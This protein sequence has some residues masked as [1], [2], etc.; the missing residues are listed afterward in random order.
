M[1]Q[2]IHTGTHVP[3]HVVP[4]VQGSARASQWNRSQWTHVALHVEQHVSQCESTII[5]PIPW[6]H[7]G[8]LCHAL[9]SS[10]SW[11]SHAAC[12]IAIAGMRQATPGEWQCNYS[13]RLAVANGPNIFQMLLVVIIKRELIILTLH[14]VAGAVYTCLFSVCF[15]F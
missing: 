11:T 8:P 6:G 13:R 9:S 7:S 1:L 10:S 5:G 14:K 4:H 2:C 15:T 3:A 12:I